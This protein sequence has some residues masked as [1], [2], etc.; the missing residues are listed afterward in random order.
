M[1]NRREMVEGGKYSEG[2]GRKGKG[3]VATGQKTEAAIGL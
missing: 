1:R 2:E 3:A